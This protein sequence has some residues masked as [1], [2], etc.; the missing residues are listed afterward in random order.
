[1]TDKIKKVFLHNGD[2]KSLG[3]TQ[4]PAIFSDDEK[5]DISRKFDK[6][7]KAMGLIHEIVNEFTNEGEVF[8]HNLFYNFCCKTKSQ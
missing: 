4:N 3:F 1:M 8:Y 5:M 6:I 2:Y 7:E